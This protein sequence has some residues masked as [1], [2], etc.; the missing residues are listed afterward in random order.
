MSRL[1]V[2][3]LKADMQSA[4]KKQKANIIGTGG[5]RVNISYMM[6]G[7]GKVASMHR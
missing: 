1:N 4:K 3:C 5:Y 2:T 6:V 7:Y